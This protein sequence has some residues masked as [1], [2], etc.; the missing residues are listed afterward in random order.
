[1]ESQSRRS[2]RPERNLPVEAAYVCL[3]VYDGATLEAL[4]SAA[5]ALPAKDESRYHVTLRYLADASVPG[6]EKLAEAVGEI[7]AAAPAFKLSLDRPGVFPNSPRVIY[8][9]VAPAAALLELQAAVDEAVRSL[10][11]KPADYA[12][13]PHITLARGEGEAATV[14]PVSWPAETVEIRRSAR[15]GRAGEIL[16]SFKLGGT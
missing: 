8:Y 14:G 3:P 2:G 16:F 7:C 13:N 4:R 5:A 12:Y 15:G 10:G 11:C 1:M 6:L 9:A